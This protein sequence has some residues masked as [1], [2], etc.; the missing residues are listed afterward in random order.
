MGL[1][2]NQELPVRILLALDDPELTPS[3]GRSLRAMGAVLAQASGE[4]SALLAL[5]EQAAFDVVILQTPIELTRAQ[6]MIKRVKA[7]AGLS[8]VL[9]L[10]ANADVH[11]KISALDAGADEV[12][13]KPF[14]MQELEAR[15]R[16]LVR[17]H[18][19]A[20]S[21]LIHHGPLSYDQ[22]GR[23]V[24]M[25]EKML[26]LSAREL[27]LLEVLL[28]RSGRMVSKDQLVE[29]LCQWGQEVSTNAIEV[30]IHRLR[31]KIE[32]GPIRILTVRGIG[33]CLEKINVPTADVADPTPPPNAH[34]GL[35]P[36]EP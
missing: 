21:A 35:A 4:D 32:V 36:H 33:Y 15:V 1:P 8:A 22:I 14:L 9:V 2:S 6:E 5:G 23:V 30:Y 12:M 20:L 31:K 3:V 34:H 24:R 19:G 29:R 16:A 11:Y 7:L 27:S 18:T 28:Q 13:S 10:S 26:E 25:E 17:R